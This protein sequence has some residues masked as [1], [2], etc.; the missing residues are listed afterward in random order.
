MSRQKTFSIFGLLLAVLSVA[1]FFAFHETVEGTGSG[2]FGFFLGS[3]AGVS[4]AAAVFFYARWRSSESNRLLED[5]EARFR[6][7]FEISPF[8]AVVTSV[9]TQRV[10]A[11]NERTASRFGIPREKT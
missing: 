7:L 8:P 9:T 11:V 2:D 3:L 5:S 1:A 4:L 10:L 6:H